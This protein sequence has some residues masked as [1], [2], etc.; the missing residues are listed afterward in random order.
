[1]SYKYNPFTGTLDLVG[2]GT[3][4]PGVLVWKGGITVATDFPTL[5]L[6]QTGWVYTILANVTDN[7]AGKTNTGQSFVT[8]DDKYCSLS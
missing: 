5:A 8:G 1:M 3:S 6:V 7:N 2:A 4:I